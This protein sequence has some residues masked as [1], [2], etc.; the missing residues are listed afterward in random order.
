[1]SN[2][3]Y[4]AVIIG[5]GP[6]GLAA[7]IHLIRQGFRTLLLEAS[8]TIGGAAVTRELTLPGFWHDVGA[9]VHL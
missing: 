4:D 5:A 6:N 3:T 9:A 2:R 1:M 7:G 8:D